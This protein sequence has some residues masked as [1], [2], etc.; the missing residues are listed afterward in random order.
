MS[1]LCGCSKSLI[2]SMSTLE[3][4]NVE[5]TKEK[6]GINVVSVDHYILNIKT[7]GRKKVFLPQHLCQRTQT[8]FIILRQNN[9]VIKKQLEISYQNS[10]VFMSTLQSIIFTLINNTTLCNFL[11]IIYVFTKFTAFKLS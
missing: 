2:N 9:I 3:N 5:S 11:K 6:I 10:G 7:N 8:L 4:F 1:T